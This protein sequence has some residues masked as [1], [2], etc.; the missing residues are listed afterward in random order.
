MSTQKAIF[1]SF[2]ICLCALRIHAQTPAAK[3]DIKPRATLLSD[4]LLMRLPAAYRQEAQ[5]L[6]GGPER[7]QQRLAAMTDDALVTAVIQALAMKPEA[8]A[9]LLDQ[10]EKEPSPAL[11]SD[12]IR[13]MGKYWDAHPEDEGILQRH[14]LSDPDA[15]VSAESYVAV[16]QVQVDALNKLL[17][18][19]LD[20]AIANGDT[21]GASK[22]YD[23]QKLG[24]RWHYGNTLP[25]FFED[26]PPVFSVVP[27]GKP[28]SVLAF[29]DFGTGTVA[30]KQTAAAM[31]EYS[32][33]HHFDF[34]LTLGDNFYPAGVTSP[35]DPRWQSEWE[36]L[37]GPIGIKFYATLGNHDWAG[38]DSP[39]AEIRYS[40][41]SPDWRMPAPYYTFTAGSVQFFAF[42]TPEVDE[43]ELKWL[44]AQ[45]AAS[46]S[47]WKV[48]YGHY[49]IYSA[50]RGDNKELIA[51]LLPILEKHHVDV[52]LNGHDHNLQA[53]RPEGGVHFFISGGAGAG[54]YNLNPYDRSVFKEKVNGFTVL[55][56]D[57]RS[58]TVSFIGTD[59]SEL[60]QKTLTK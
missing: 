9:F 14:L 56:A 44:D 57:N 53:L 39:A 10:L 13:S 40:Q 38:P 59:G 12:I 58:L 28:I 60:Y 43:T 33:H 24:I 36:Q 2:G 7:Y 1:L 15:G 4:S 46:T 6:V 16:H 20:E 48:V 29:G 52:Y 50:T 32:E 37:Y 35:E 21:S 54:L 22:L 47:K 23:A 27:P 26:P 8:S 42:D 51:R 19:R 41:R 11:R 30:Q 31:V 34:G 25:A 55:D 5:N 45:L 3:P 17:A 49:H 18:Q